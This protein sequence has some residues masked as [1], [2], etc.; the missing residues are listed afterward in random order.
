MLIQHQRAKHFKCVVCHKRLGSAHGM[1][2]HVFQVHKQQIDRFE[3]KTKR[4]IDVSSLVS[5]LFFF[6]C[7]CCL[8]GFC[9]IVTWVFVCDFFNLR[10]F[11]FCD[12][13]SV[14]FAVCYFEWGHGIVFFLFYVFKL[15]Q[16]KNEVKPN[17]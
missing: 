15:K 1:M 11:C 8:F 4:F 17:Y 9:S 14:T 7:V 12:V 2:V 5:L 6:V 3:I 13:F 16:R 10:N